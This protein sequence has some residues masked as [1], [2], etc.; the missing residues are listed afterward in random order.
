MVKIGIVGGGIMGLSS[1]IRLQCEFP[2]V[3]IT[4]IS[5]KFSPETT[6]DGRIIF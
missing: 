1:A 5:E 6:A 4:L 2:D 3:E